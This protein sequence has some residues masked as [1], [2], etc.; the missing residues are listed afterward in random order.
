[1]GLR[2]IDAVQFRDGSTWHLMDLRPGLA[3]LR[4]A[5]LE[6]VY[7]A[8][9]ELDPRGTVLDLGANIGMFTV[10]A[11]R[12]LVP[13]GHVIAVE[14]NPEVADVLRRNLDE[15][16]VSNVE[17]IQAA[18]FTTD[19]VA[20]LQLAGHSLGAT[21][22]ATNPRGK[23][24]I[25]PTINVSR[26]VKGIGTVDL[27]KVDIEGAEWSVFFDSDP[28]MWKNIK[29]IAMEFHL[30]SSGGRTPADLAHH[31]SCMGYSN[32]QVDHPPGLYGYLWAELS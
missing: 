14:P 27:L 4:D 6:R 10:L 11:A 31:L 1:V 30:D 32:I 2:D 15:N 22:S 29:R 17:L 13:E 18:A 23:V 5:Y 28:G 19:G 16:R 8:R 12:R 26:L 9:F 20:R 25:V 24:V 7:D 3:A 21:I